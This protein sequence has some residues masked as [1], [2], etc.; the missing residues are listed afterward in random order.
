MSNVGNSDELMQKSDCIIL[1]TDHNEF[2]N[3]DLNKLKGNNIKVII[4][5]RNCLDKDEIKSLGISYHG[6]GRG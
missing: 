4:D 5:G 1:V 2:K 3:M 6:I